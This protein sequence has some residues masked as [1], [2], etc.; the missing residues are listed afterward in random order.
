MRRRRRAFARRLAIRRKVLGEEHPDTANSYNNLASNQNAQG[1][2]ALAEEGCRKA[3]AIYRKVLGEEHPDTAGSYNNLAGN[4]NAQ[5]KYAE[6]EEGYRKALAICRKVLGE[7]HPDTAL[8]YNSLASNQSD[9]GKYAQAEECY[10]KALAICRKV[11]GEEHPHTATSYN[12]L[13]GNQDDQGKHAEAEEGYRKALAIYR[14]VLGEEHPDTAR[15]YNN[16]AANQNAQGKYA[17]AEEGSGRPWP[18][19]ARCSA[20]NTP[21]RPPATTTWRTTSRGRAS[22]REAEVGLR[23]ALAIRRK[24]LG[25]EHPHTAH[26]YK[27]LAYNQNAQGKYALAEEYWQKAADC[28]DKARSRL[29]RTGLDRA[30][31]TSERSPL[32]SLAAVLARNGKASAAWERFEQSLG[33]GAW[34]DL[35]ARLR[36]PLAERA[37]QDQLVAR[38]NRL[39]LLVERTFSARKPSAEQLG[40]RKELLTQ[41]RQAQD[42]LNAF[43]ASLEKRY[44]PVGGQVFD[45]AAIQAALPADA[46]LVAWIDLAGKPKAKDPN[47]EHWAVLLRSAGDPIFVRLSGSGDRGDWSDVDSRLPA[48][49]R[50]RCKASAASGSRWRNGWASSVWPPWRSIWRRRTACPP[51]AT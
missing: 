32:P 36:R 37:R 9:Q 44:G 15:S 49:L 4:Q 47:G 5:G 18:S 2:Y 38:L 51:S 29:A 19:A 24:V 34:D 43:T 13:A 41:Q 25:E 45:R 30:A 40:D 7:E 8:S 12:N 48:E 10:R 27:I 46:A 31:K 42:D 14:K 6:A 23:K 21:T 11:L 50:L 39:D 28:F 35:S 20:R 22:T 26:S 16:L 3:L 1:K 17:L 33:R